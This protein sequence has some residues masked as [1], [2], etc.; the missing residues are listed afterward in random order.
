MSTALTIDA[1]NPRNRKAQVF[2]ALLLAKNQ[3]TDDFTTA[4]P[5][6]AGSGAPNHNAAVINEI[7]IR[8]DASDSD[9]LLYRAVNTS[10]TW[11]TVVGSELTDL[12]AATNTWTAA[13]TFS[14]ASGVTTNTLTERT[15]AAGVTI[16]G[17]L[18]K[19]GYT[20][21][22]DLAGSPTVEGQLAYNAD[23][24]ELYD[25]AAARI[26]LAN[27]DIGVTVQAY[28]ATLAALVNYG[29]DRQVFATIAVADSGTN[30]A[31]LTLQLN[32]LDGST[33]IAA[34]RQ[35]LILT[36]TTQ[37]APAGQPEASVTF[38]TASTGSIIASGQG[39]CLAETS[40]AG[41]FACTAT[42]TDNE[43]IYFFA[44]TAARVS[45]LTKS[46]AVVGSNTDAATWS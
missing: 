38:G 35:V 26:I 46:C 43:T 28:S 23:H 29:L 12:L 42:N 22:G 14:H 37:Y 7:Y 13:N 30:D 27:D 34:A 3:D 4:I 17:L 18:V 5:L 44:Q 8:T 25:G 33:A 45:D 20:V 19:D 10:G 6:S 24:L 39:W 21:Y 36:S 40:V 32:R 9:L 16:D 2:A 11:E 31:A 41:A 15:A 1:S